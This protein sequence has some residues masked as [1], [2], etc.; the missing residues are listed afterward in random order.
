MYP[1]LKAELVRRHIS[2]PALAES[3][4][5]SHGTMYLKLSGKAELTLRQA[6]Q[7][8]D[9]LGIDLPLEVLFDLTDDKSA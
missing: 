4:G 7:I 6:K 9:L 2:V 8:K 5:I 3:L 1:N